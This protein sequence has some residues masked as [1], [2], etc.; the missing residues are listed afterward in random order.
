MNLLLLVLAV[1]LF[2]TM[3]YPLL[4]TDVKTNIPRVK[5]AA[6]KKEGNAR[7]ENLPNILDNFVLNENTFFHPFSIADRTVNV[8][9]T[10]TESVQ[11]Q[12]NIADV[13]IPA[14]LDYAIV[15]EKNLFHPERKMPPEKKDEQIVVRPDLIFY[16]SVITGEKKIAYIE[17]KKNPYSTPGRGKR[18]VPFVEGSMIGG[19]IL[20]EVN[21]EFIVLVRGQ[22]KMVVNLRDQKDRKT[23]ETTATGLRS[24][25]A[26]TKPQ[27]PT[28]PQ[29]SAGQA[30]GPMPGLQ[31]DKP[32]TT[33]SRR[34]S[35]PPKQI[36]INNKD[37]NPVK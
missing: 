5:A 4:S 30:S 19:Y 33:R 25:A 7:S 1:A 6:I 29:I 9:E 15:T 11:K 23:A 27:T 26:T 10:K 35:Y 37:M 16:G 8:P 13:N 22:D 3:A 14:A 21:P 28:G 36:I 20:K 12:E 18:Q 24:T 32:A 17:D 31:P 2:F 34:P